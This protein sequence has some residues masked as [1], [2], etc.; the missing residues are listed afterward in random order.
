MYIDETNIIEDCDEQAA[1]A[2]LLYSGHLF[3]NN[4]KNNQGEYT[5]GLYFN[6]SDT[7]EYACADAEP[8]KFNDGENPS[9]IIELYKYFKQN[10]K[11]G[12]TV[13]VC[14]K[15]GIQPIKS[16][17]NRMIEEGSWDENLE[18][19]PF[20][21]K[22]RPRLIPV[23]PEKDRTKIIDGIEFPLRKK[24]KNLFKKLYE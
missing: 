24:L 1:L 23:V 22:D 11:W 18:K 2:C 16:I 13:W 7:F 20:K 4:I 9:E 3:I 12:P 15:R 17:K 6:C 21:I 19:L 5:T 8:I 14:L 10:Q